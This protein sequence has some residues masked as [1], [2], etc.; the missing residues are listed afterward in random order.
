MLKFEFYLKFSKFV[1]FNTSEHPF[2][3][4]VRQKDQDPWLISWWFVLCCVVPRN[5]LRSNIV[6]RS[7]K[8]RSADSWRLSLPCLDIYWTHHVPLTLIS[9]LPTKLAFEVDRSGV[10]NQ[11]RVCCSWKFCEVKLLQAY[12]IGERN[13]HQQEAILYTHCLLDIYYVADARNNLLNDS[14]SRWML[15]AVTQL[16]A[17]T[18]MLDATF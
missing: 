2:W 3:G 5:E 15:S 4:H 13:Y 7:V 6:G 12:D 9:L 8:N 1:F 16:L 11:N 18:M 14:I 17:L 10:R